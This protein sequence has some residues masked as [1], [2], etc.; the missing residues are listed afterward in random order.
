[1]FIDELLNVRASVGVLLVR[2][3]LRWSSRYSGDWVGFPVSTSS[4]ILPS[5]YRLCFDVIYHVS[6][7]VIYL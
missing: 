6:E 1:M 7:L 2:V 4:T 3:A 5:I